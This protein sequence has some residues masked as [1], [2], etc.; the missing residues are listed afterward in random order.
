MLSRQA[1]KTAGTNFANGP[2]GAQFEGLDDVPEVKNLRRLQKPQ[3]VTIERPKYDE[4]FLFF[5]GVDGRWFY[6]RCNFNRPS[7]KGP[8]VEEEEEGA[9]EELDDGNEDVASSEEQ[10]VSNPF[11]ASSTQRATPNYINIRRTRPSATTSRYAKAD[12]PHFRSQRSRVYE[13]ADDC[14]CETSSFCA[15]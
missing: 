9:E 6:L 12:T 2:G 11:L 5:K 15:R 13:T 10:A 3:Y 8:P 14:C 7:T 4:T 1:G